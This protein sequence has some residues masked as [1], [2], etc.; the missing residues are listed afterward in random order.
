[1]IAPT[2]LIVLAFS[3]GQAGPGGG[4]SDA[5]LADPYVDGSYGYTIRPPEGWHVI[6]QRVPEARGVTLLRM[7]HQIDRK[8]IEELL[9]KQTSTTRQAPMGEMLREIHHALQLE[10]SNVEVLSQ[11]V[12]EIAGRPGALIAATFWREGYQWLRLEAIIELRP[13]QY[14]VLLYNGP[15]ER[16]PRS[17][18]LFHFVLGSLRLIKDRLS[19]AEMDKALTVGKQWLA[20]ISAEDMRKAIIPEQYLKIMLDG[21]PIGFVRIQQG[22]GTSKGNDGI[23]IRE[24]GW[25]FESDGRIRRL[26]SNMFVSFDRHSEKWKTSVTTLVPAEGMRPAYI[27]NALEEG[28][29]TQD[30]LLTSQ[31]YQIGQPVTENP[32]R[33]VP[34]TYVAR[35]LVRMLPQL[36]G[37]LSRPRWLAFVEFDHQRVDMVLRVVE[38]KG[39]G[40]PTAG[41]MRDKAYRIEQREGLAGEPSI[42]YV[43]E[44]GRV[45]MVK[46]GRLTM[47]P[48]KAAALEKLFE[49]RVTAADREMA[50]LEKEYEDRQRRFVPRRRSKGQ[51]K[52]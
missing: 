16:R 24:R 13:Q 31:A 9:L 8:K 29:R 10:Y 27:E 4:V 5:Q 45:L 34:D 41:A 47:L 51:Q 40:N 17:E 2:M 7:V 28:L 25:T 18:P 20:D 23:R 48:A 21:A 44:E 15:A 1:M 11:Q 43:D 19:P 36:I 30:V 3:S 49:A 12:Q 39:V 35:A 38:L 42:L 37:D 46:A 22:P 32:A 52:P 6:R 50:R 33:E 26:Q 14:Y